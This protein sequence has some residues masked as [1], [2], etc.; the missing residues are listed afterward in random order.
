MSKTHIKT[1]AFL[2]V[3]S[4]SLFSFGC[5][6]NIRQGERRYADPANELDS[7]TQVLQGYELPVSY[8][9]DRRNGHRQFRFSGILKSRTDK[10]RIADIYIP[11]SYDVS[12]PMFE[13]VSAAFSNEGKPPIYLYLHSAKSK[14]DINPARI[15]KTLPAL[16]LD[17]QTG[18]QAHDTNRI[19]PPK[20][21]LSFLK[22]NCVPSEEIFCENCIAQPN[23]NICER[24][25]I[26]K[27]T[28]EWEN[29]RQSA[30]WMMKSCYFLSVPIDVIG[31]LF[32]A[33]PFNADP[34]DLI[35]EI[36]FHRTESKI[37][38]EM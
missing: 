35:D 7:S 21:F 11:N 26:I 4:S 24:K 37:N 12:K 3:M 32:I 34:I 1:I 27:P 25:W 17:I 22:E 16:V 6:Y 33:A 15:K 9:F 2:L 31:V 29:R 10:D 14:P 13:E 28:V 8:R 23:K 30:S 19:G 36:L 38:K 18:N 20:I 5:S